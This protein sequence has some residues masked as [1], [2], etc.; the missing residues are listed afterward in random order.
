M[1]IKKLRSYSYWSWIRNKQIIAP[2]CRTSNG[3]WTTPRLNADV[4]LNM[5]PMIVTEWPVKLLSVQKGR[6]RYLVFWMEVQGMN[7][8]MNPQKVILEAIN[9][10]NGRKW[11]SFTKNTKIISVA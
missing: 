4:W 9:A 7:S 6:G 1:K 8:E 3:N 2:A 10:T 11:Y 5:I